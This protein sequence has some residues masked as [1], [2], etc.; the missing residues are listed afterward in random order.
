MK[1]SALLLLA[2]AMP[3]AITGCGKTDT[4]SV[5]AN[6]ADKLCNAIKDAGLTKQCSA[7]TPNSEIGIIIDAND[8]EAARNLCA[9]ITDSMKP[10]AT[11]LPG[12]WKLQ[13]FSPYRDDKPLVACALN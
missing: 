11:S 5:A 10:L 9:K 2:L 3:T 8:E 4:P 6:V 7:S 13:I 1:S 12:R